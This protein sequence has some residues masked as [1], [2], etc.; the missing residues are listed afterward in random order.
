MPTP[1]RVEEGN[2]T[3]ALFASGMSVLRSLRT[4]HAD[5]QHAREPGDLQH[6]LVRRPRPVREGHKPHGGRA[7]AGEAGVCRSTCDAAEQGR[8]TFGGGC[9]GKGRDEGEH[10]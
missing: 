8:A 7:R 4:R 5:K 10:R 1:F 2:T 9:G 6:A 3:A